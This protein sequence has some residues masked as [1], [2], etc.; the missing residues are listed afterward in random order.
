[1]HDRESNCPADSSEGLL[2]LDASLLDAE[3]AGR[4]NHPAAQVL[5]P[6]SA[7]GRAASMF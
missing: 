3:R 2:A 1:V 6:H 7:N 5:A 4:A